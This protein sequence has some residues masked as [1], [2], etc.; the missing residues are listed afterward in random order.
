MSVGRVGCV[1]MY[2]KR[3]RVTLTNFGYLSCTSLCCKSLTLRYAKNTLAH[4]L[5]CII[6]WKE[7]ISLLINVFTIWNV[8]QIA[9]ISY[10]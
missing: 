6:Y 2:C 1:V 3:E 4:E 9:N 5:N 8:E 10:A 7:A